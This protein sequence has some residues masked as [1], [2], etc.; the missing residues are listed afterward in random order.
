MG[1]GGVPQRRGG[2]IDDLRRHR[3]VT[4]CTIAGGLARTGT[5][6]GTRT[7]AC[8]GACSG[9]GACSSA[10]P[11]SDSDAK[12]DAIAIA[13]HDFTEPGPI[14]QLA[15]PELLVAQYLDVHTDPGQR[16]ER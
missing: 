8:S 1:T 14:Q 7:G 11:H 3:T 12:P 10:R 15:D 13:G 16:R 5:R 9:T 6:A 4:D 2:S